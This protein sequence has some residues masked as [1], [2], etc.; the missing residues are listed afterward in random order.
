MI[1]TVEIKLS[2][3]VEVKPIGD[4]QKEV[5]KNYDKGLNCT[6]LSVGRYVKKILTMQM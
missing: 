5:F 2:D 6:H 3:M 1:D 4:N